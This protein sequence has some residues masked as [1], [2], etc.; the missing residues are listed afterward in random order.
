MKHNTLAKIWSLLSAQQRK[1]AVALLG[2]MLAGMVLETL[3]VGLVIPVMAIITDEN[4][5]KSYPRLQPALDFLGNPEQKTLIVWAMLSLVAIYIVKTG[6]LA[7]LVWKQSRFA[8]GVQASISQRLFTTYLRQPYMFHLQRNSATLIQ[9][10]TQEVSQF[11]F[12]AI[13]PGMGLITELL[14]LIGLAAL[15]VAAEPVGAVA[16]VVTL[17]GAALVFH[18]VTRLKVTSW[19]V[20]RQLHDRQRLQHLQQGLGGAKDVKLLGRESD[21]LSQ[22][23]THSDRT[24]HIGQRMQTLNQLPRLWI[25]MLAIVGLATIVLIMVAQGKSI[26]TIAPTLGLFTAAAFR[27]MPSMTRL[28]SYTQSIRHGLPTTNTLC[29]ELALAAPAP[30]LL[31]AGSA[32]PW[33]EIQLRDVS[34]TYPGTPAPSLSR[35]TLSIQRGETVGF[36]GPSGS[37]KSTLVDVV[38]GLLTPGAGQV[39]LDAEDIQKNLRAWQNQ[40]G[41]VPQ[42]IYLTDDTL[43]RNVAFGLPNDTIDD[44]AVA[45]ALKSAQLEEF[46]AALP[47]MAQ[48]IVGERGVRLSGG[49]RQRIGIARALYHDPAVLV[50]DEATSALDTPTEQGVMEAITALHG[51]KTILIVAHRMS[52][53]EHC[54]RLFRLEGGALTRPALKTEASPNR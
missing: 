10:A 1:S 53:V 19:G 15:L 34:F 39:L 13:L 35:L 52:T 23:K 9:N 4:L 42:S 54:D 33:K 46:V 31:P 26:G 2:L 36:V 44:A 22:F 5:T 47:E 29:A 32:A 37:G 38:L 45:R 18:K 28:L 11:T 27:L 20:A 43:R 51:T 21:F 24:A 8:F 49:Q 50:L 6:F 17:G 48:T 30:P 40:I 7:F 41:Y 3:G 25:E 14:V 12:G 16:V